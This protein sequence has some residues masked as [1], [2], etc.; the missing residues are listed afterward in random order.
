MHDVLARANSDPAHGRAPGE[1]AVPIL[2]VIS[3]LGEWVG[4]LNGKK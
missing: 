3:W 2:P 4:K 1:M